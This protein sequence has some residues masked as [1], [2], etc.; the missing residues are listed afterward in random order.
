MPNIICCLYKTV[1]GTHDSMKVLRN[2]MS[3]RIPHVNLAGADSS[4]V[5]YVIHAG[6]PYSCQGALT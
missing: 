4:M 3:A 5:R 2:N 1:P 6:V